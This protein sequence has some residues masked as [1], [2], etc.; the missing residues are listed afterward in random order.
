M[1]HEERPGRVAG[2]FKVDGEGGD[3]S[4][5]VVMMAMMTVVVILRVGWDGRTG[6]HDDAQ[7]GKHPDLEFHSFLLF[8]PVISKSTRRP[9]LTLVI[10]ESLAFSFNRRND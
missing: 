9:V 8:S 6:Q 4:L 7:K 1:R 3:H 2:P 10:C 5:V